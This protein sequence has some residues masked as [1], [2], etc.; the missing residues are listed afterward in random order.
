MKLIKPQLEILHILWSSDRPLSLQEITDRSGYRFAGR[1]IV[2]AVIEDLLAKD[3]I[4]RAGAFHGFSDKRENVVTQYSA[5][6]R[7]DEYYAEK[8]KGIAPWNLSN[9][10]KII[11]ASGRLSL[12]QLREL[13]AILEEKLKHFGN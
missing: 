9:L 8:F 1:F 2:S 4:Y 3:A 7:F 5:R 13:Y 6:I 12:M 11:L 10:I